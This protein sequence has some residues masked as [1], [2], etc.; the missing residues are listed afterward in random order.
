MISDTPSWGRGGGGGTG[1]VWEGDG[2]AGRW[3]CGSAGGREMV[4]KVKNL[5]DMGCV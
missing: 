1:V 3:S 2:W 4:E 5:G